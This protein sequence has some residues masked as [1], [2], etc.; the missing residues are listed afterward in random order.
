LYAHVEFAGMVVL[1]SLKI[2]SEKDAV[3]VLWS[4]ILNFAAYK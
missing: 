2:S 3:F 1:A 4:F